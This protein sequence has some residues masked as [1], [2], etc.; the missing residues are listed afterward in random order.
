M[1]SVIRE[2]FYYGVWNS[3]LRMII[4]VINSG[5]LLK[6]KKRV[7]LS[8]VGTNDAGKL[9]KEGDG[10]ILTALN[11]YEKKRF[12]KVF[13]LWTS[14]R[15]ENA[16]YDKISQYLEKEIVKRR[17][18]RDVRRVYFDFHNVTDHNE[19][20]PKLIGF[21]RNTFE[22]TKHNITAAIA[23]GTPSIQACW[24]LI[25]ESGDF[26]LNLIRSNEPEYGLPAVVPVKLDTNLPKITRLKE[27]NIK[28]N[29]M[30]R[31]LLPYVLMDTGRSELK[32]GEI[33]IPLSP[34]Q[35]CYYRYFS[36]RVKNNEGDLKLKGYAMPREFCE[37]IVNYYEESY[38]E[39][40]L[41]IKSYKDKLIKFEN[42]DASTFRSNV[43]KLNK[44]IETELNNPPLK[45]FFTV[46]ATGPNQAKSYGVNIPKEK[47]IIKK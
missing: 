13:L 8:F 21:L 10:A 4:L 15:K 43:S 6:D 27:E 33:L 34:L 24:I 3:C 41:N 14:S 11:Y 5:G 30:N 23:S 39:H 36:E 7:F 1:M 19:I 17:I 46:K 31:S 18:C 25:A 29:R 22:E 45:D 42:I 37:R 47:I 12:D 44:R 2:G 38:K 40:D 26:K 32:I 28:L 16:D 9:H 35:F 20:Y